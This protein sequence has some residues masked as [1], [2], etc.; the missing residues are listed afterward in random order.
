MTPIQRHGWPWNIVN[1]F[2]ESEEAAERT[3]MVVLDGS[4][5][6]FLLSGF[7]RDRA[8][9]ARTTGFR[10]TQVRNTMQRRTE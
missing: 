10:F 1:M 7:L 2:R 6:R 9:M 4:S 5:L 3:I 8:L